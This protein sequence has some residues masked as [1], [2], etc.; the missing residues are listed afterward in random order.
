MDC[1]LAKTTKSKKAFVRGVASPERTS[2][3]ILSECNYMSYRKP[4][5]DNTVDNCPIECPLAFA[6]YISL[7]NSTGQWSEPITSERIPADLTL[8]F[9]F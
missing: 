2:G 7:S 3:K 5:K 1:V 6:P 9:S 8:L 4:V